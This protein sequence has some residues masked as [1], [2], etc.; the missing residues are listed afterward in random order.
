MHRSSSS[1][2]LSLRRRAAL[3]LVGV[4]WLAAALLPAAAFAAQAPAEVTLRS[5]WTVRLESDGQGSD[6]RGAQ[7]LAL[8]GALGGAKGIAT[9]QDTVT[10]PAGGDGPYSIDSTLTP[11]GALA[12]LLRRLHWVRSASGRM[13]SGQADLLVATSR[14]GDDPPTTVRIVGGRM[15]LQAGAQPVQD[16]A[17]PR[18][19]LDP[20][21]L[22]WG[23][24][25]RPLPVEP[26][27]LPLLINGEVHTAHVVPQPVTLQW[28]GQP[29]ACTLL[30][31]K[32]DDSSARLRIWLRQSDGLP[33]QVELGLGE[34]YGLDVV[35]TLARVPEG[36][37]RLQREAPLAAAR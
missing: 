18:G 31:A 36:L 35:Q 28:Q 6:A 32:S 3:A 7:L 17:A 25:Q 10:L 12:A 27:V 29:V 26:F 20:L 9:A 34:R 11:R 24:L 4:A 33:L 15:D 13:H 2:P 14:R 30:D 1:L 37:D 8:L 16:K 5:D 19:L 21:T 23:Y 22:G